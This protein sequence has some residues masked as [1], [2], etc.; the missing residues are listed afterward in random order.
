MGWGPI[1]VYT[2]RPAKKPTKLLDHFV[3]RGAATVELVSWEKGEEPHRAHQYSF[4]ADCGLV[5]FCTNCGARMCAGCG[6][7]PLVYMTDE[8]PYVACTRDECKASLWGH[9][10]ELNNG[11]G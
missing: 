11:A 5:I 7:H 8:G 3:G 4:N 2:D 9:Y 10:E 1:V 6:S